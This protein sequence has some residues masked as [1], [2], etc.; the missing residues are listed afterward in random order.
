MCCVAALPAPC[1]CTGKEQL[2]FKQG[3]VINLKRVPP[4]EGWGLGAL[5]G[6]VCLFLCMCPSKRY[7]LQTTQPRETAAPQ[8]YPC[9][10]TSTDNCRCQTRAERLGVDY[11]RPDVLSSARVRVVGLVAP[12]APH[13]LE[14][15]K[16][17]SG[18]VQQ[19]Q[20][21]CIHQLLLVH[22]SIAPYTTC[23]DEAHMVPCGGTLRVCIARSVGCSGIRTTYKSRL[24]FFYLH[25]LACTFM[26]S[27]VALLAEAEGVQ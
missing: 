21:P 15:L 7:F 18:F 11:N 4:G 22:V 26:S 24:L 27:S 14:E 10:S 3:D 20:A 16:N 9:L 23:F 6:K 19:Y 13:I 25:R 5:N 8:V 1:M 17:V 12:H 2:S